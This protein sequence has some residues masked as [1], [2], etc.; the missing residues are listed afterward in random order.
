[1]IMAK[2]SLPTNQNGE[3]ATGSQP[4]TA[5]QLTRAIGVNARRPEKNPI[6]MNTIET[7]AGFKRDQPNEFMA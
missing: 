4:Q 3:P 1:M 2:V 6:P 5:N 7:N